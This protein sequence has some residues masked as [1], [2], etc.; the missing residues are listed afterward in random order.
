MSFATANAVV[1]S[2]VKSQGNNMLQSDDLSVGKIQLSRRKV[3]L[4]GA[5]IIASGLVTSALPSFALAQPS[6]GFAP[7]MQIS[8]LLVN[9][10]LDD[11]VGQRM[12]ALLDSEEQGLLD[13]INQLLAIARAHNAFKVEDFFPAI[14]QGKLQDLAHK[15]IFGWY[16]GSL[17]PT[18]SAKTFAYE[19]AL[20]WHTTLDVITIPSYGI[21][22]PNNWQRA[23][24]P[25]L[26]VPQF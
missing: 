26:P 1:L 4:S 12:L 5:V 22:G 14:P 24:T 21:S 13:N 8:R 19:Q 23:N 6:P 11:A 3:L 2:N 18:R 10:Q 25:V 20:T 17:A 9:H 16:T 7:F 15:I